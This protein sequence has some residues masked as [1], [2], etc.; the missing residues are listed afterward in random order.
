MRRR[1]QIPIL[2][3]ALFLAGCERSSTESEPTEISVSATATSEGGG[4]ITERAS[5]SEENARVES[6]H[7]R[8]QE[9]D[10]R[11]PRRKMQVGTAKSKAVRM[12]RTGEL[13]LSDGLVVLLDGVTCSQQGY[14]YLSRLLL[15]PEVDL[16]V[17][18]NDGAQSAQVPAD[19]WILQRIG[20]STGT[21][22]PIE[23][24]IMSGWCDPKRTTSSPNNDRYAALESA[25]ASER[26]AYKASAP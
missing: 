6:A 11:F 18:R 16:L 2:F 24:G 14:E 10:R 5:T 21:T 20:D 19:V 3:I 12:S 26:D 17:A 4:G 13:E 23:S 25:F 8:V 9:I 22:Y 7:A 15:D 1:R